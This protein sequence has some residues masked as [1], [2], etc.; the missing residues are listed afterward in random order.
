MPK[1]PPG[2]FA[3]QMVERALPGV[4]QVSR[5]GRG[6]GA[7]VVWSGDG[8]VLT[9][10][11]V[12]AGGR[13][14]PR[15]GPRRGPRRGRRRGGRPGGLRI[16]LGDGRVFDARVVG[17]GRELDLAL[18]K[19]EAEGLAAVPVGDSDSLR[20]GEMVFAIGHPWGMTGTVTAGVVSGVDERPGGAGG[21]AG[22]PGGGARYVQ[23]DVALAPGNS[24][25]PL[26]NARG[27]VVGINAMIFGGLS[28][29]V[30]SNAAG[31]WIARVTGTERPRP[32]LGVELVHA[33]LGGGR[34]GFV[35]S[36]VLPDGP[37]ARAGML[38]GDVILGFEDWPVG[39]VR[40]LVE[41]LERAGMSDPAKP[42][43]RLRVVRGATVSVVEVD[44][45]VSGPGR[46]A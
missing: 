24:G 38:V 27:R 39:D 31:A 15:P 5:E 41:G 2:G 45:G 17:L 16:T 25:G 12:V 34:A 33:L 7:G 20:V 23:S 8:L 19:V 13:P 22:G 32:R 4:V 3:S 26:L 29:A 40:A 1:T 46:A 10:H 30:P 14:G 44:L 43:A 37:A 35:V 21:A 28:L 11:H 42:V 9:N 18:L 36:A 6:A